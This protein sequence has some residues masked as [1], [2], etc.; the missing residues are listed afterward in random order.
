MDVSQAARPAIGNPKVSEHTL[1]VSI[2]SAKDSHGLAELLDFADSSKG[3]CLEWSY[4]NP[5]LL[6][7]PDLCPREEFSQTIC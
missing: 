3:S 5:Y 4:H 2:S 6:H 1:L 7:I